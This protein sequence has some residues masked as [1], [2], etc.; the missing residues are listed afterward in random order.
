MCIEPA[1]TPVE[2][3]LHNKRLEFCIFKKYI[4]VFQLKY[5]R[6]ILNGSREEGR[7]LYYNIFT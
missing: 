7:I 2:Q 4:L 1:F 6:I 3:L 5:F